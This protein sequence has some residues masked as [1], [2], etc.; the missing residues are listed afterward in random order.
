MKDKLTHYLIITYLVLYHNTFFVSQNILLRIWWNLLSRF[1]IAK[2]KVTHKWNLKNLGSH[3][4]K[5]INH[6]ASIRVYTETANLFEHS[7]KDSMKLVTETKSKILK[8]CYTSAI[9]WLVQTGR[10]RPDFQILEPILMQQWR[11]PETNRVGGTY[12]VLLRKQSTRSLW[13]LVYE[14]HWIHLLT[15]HWNYMLYFFNC[16]SEYDIP[17]HFA[18]PGVR[19]T[20]KDM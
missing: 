14:Y 10:D 19:K 9:Q 2:I 17:F 16:P 20:E 1:P 7:F 15:K 11:L 4:S 12:S 3:M 8:C 18:F 6:I 5:F 13:K